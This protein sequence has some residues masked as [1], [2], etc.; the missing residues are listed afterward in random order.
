MTQQDDSDDDTADARIKVSVSRVAIS[1]I[2]QIRS[3]W[4]APA[5]SPPNFNTT[6]MIANLKEPEPRREA[7]LKLLARS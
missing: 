4:F 5:V 2:H 1:S 7:T 3:T 6:E